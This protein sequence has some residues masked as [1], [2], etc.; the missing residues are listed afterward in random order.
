M[1]V[2]CVGEQATLDVN[3]VGQHIRVLAGPN[4]PFWQLVTAELW[5]PQTLAVF[6]QFI[7]K[8]H[9]Y[10]DL[11]SWIGPT[12]LY[13]CRLARAAYG[14]EPDPVAFAE[15]RSNIALNEPLTA[16]VK[17]FNLCI[18]TRSGEAAFGSRTEGGDSTSSLLFS[19]G[20]T[21][22]TVK[23]LTF[24]DFIEHN[25]IEDCNFVKIDIE[26]GEFLV[27]PTMLE[28]LQ[29]HRP[30]VHLSLHPCFVYP[31]FFEDRP[32]INVFWRAA[33]VF[34]SFCVTV[35]ILRR[36]R[37]YRFLYD[38]HGNPLTFLQLLRICRRTLSVVATDSVWKTE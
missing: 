5:E 18:A 25:K 37:F 3:S 34:V 8:E 31:D 10:I 27:L 28:Y 30:T 23:A 14:I 4:D 9:S 22:W 6:R 32:R 38:D 17:L 2:I 16:D 12:L 20:K 15:L 24:A 19:K 11:G 33:R 7:D 1:K 29:Q 36:L 35:N 13:G 26:G 21:A